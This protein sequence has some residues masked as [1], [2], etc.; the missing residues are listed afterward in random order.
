VCQWCILMVE[1]L[2]KPVSS[3]KLFSTL[4]FAGNVSSVRIAA[5]LSEPDMPEVRT[6]T[7]SSTAIATFNGSAAFQSSA[8]NS[9]KR[10]SAAVT[11]N[12]A[13]LTWGSV[14]AA[15]AGTQADTGP[16][17][18]LTAVAAGDSTYDTSPLTD[19]FA[20]RGITLAIPAGKLTTIVGAVGAGKTA[21]LC[22]L[23]GEM[24]LENDGGSIVFE[25]NGSGT[26][27]NATALPLIA[28][29]AQQVGQ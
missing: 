8:S 23:L 19:P 4:F 5:F 18:P 2:C 3:Y 28:Y 11:I 25:A 20:L 7:A 14:P 1:A 15:N 13:T 24:S 17:A 21:L 16:A 6:T 22:A 12:K 26:K 27:V 29:C 10:S 9:D